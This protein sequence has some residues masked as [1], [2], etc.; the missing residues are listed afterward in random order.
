VHSGFNQL[1]A[2]KTAPLGEIIIIPTPQP[3]LQTDPSKC[4]FYGVKVV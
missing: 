2:S 1:R 3:L 4:N